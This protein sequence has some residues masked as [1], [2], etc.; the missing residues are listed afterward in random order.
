MPCP[1]YLPQKFPSKPASALI[2]KLAAEIKAKKR[3]HI[4]TNFLHSSFLFLRTHSHNHP[5]FHSKFRYFYKQCENLNTSPSNIPYLI[6]IR[7]LPRSF[8]DQEHHN[9]RLHSNFS[10]L[11]LSHGLHFA[12]ILSLLM[13]GLQ[14]PPPLLPDSS[15][16]R[17]YKPSTAMWY[18]CLIYQALNQNPTFSTMKKSSVSLASL[19]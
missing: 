17:T 2:Y 7:L 10:Y 11:P 8:F 18:S 6:D 1:R 19:S 16:F 14:W 3:E 13:R 5:K 12:S 9:A 4:V 15:T